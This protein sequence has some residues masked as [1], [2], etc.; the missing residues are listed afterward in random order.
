MLAAG[1]VDFGI[2]G[3]QERDSGNEV[4]RFGE[5]MLFQIMRDSNTDAIAA[6]GARRI[7]SADPHAFNCLKN[8]Y[9]DLPPVERF[10]QFADEFGTP[11]VLGVL[12]LHEAQRYIADRGIDEIYRHEM[13]LFSTLQ[14]GLAD[15]DGDGTDDILTVGE[16]H[17]EEPDLPLDVL[18]L[19]V[20]Y[21]N[22]DGS[23]SGWPAGNSVGA[24]RPAAPP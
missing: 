1:G 15:I 8:E 2:L 13:E 14:E 21:L 24:Q 16:P 4:R 18:K 3:R 7:V 19:G 5:E 12:G 17:F 22:A 9:D 11:N 20:Y 10:L 6:S 23:L